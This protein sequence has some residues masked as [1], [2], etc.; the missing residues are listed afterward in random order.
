MGPFPAF[1]L[2]SCCNNTEHDFLHDSYPQPSV[3]SGWLQT[4]WRLPQSW[5]YISPSASNLKSWIGLKNVFF[6]LYI[7]AYCGLVFRIINQFSLIAFLLYE[8]PPW[9]SAR[10]PRGRVTLLLSYHLLCYFNL[11]HRF[12]VPNILY[13]VNKWNGLYSMDKKLFLFRLFIQTNSNSHIVE[14]QS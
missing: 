2:F 11:I 10:I 13:V 7:W 12:N 3:C 9:E 14:L 4:F 1:T 8:Q 6:S 5:I